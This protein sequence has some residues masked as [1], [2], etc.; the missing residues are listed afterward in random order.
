MRLEDELVATQPQDD[1]RVA[2]VD[3]RV[4]GLAEMR[5]VQGHGASIGVS[6]DAL[7][8]T[9]LARPASGA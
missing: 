8:Q 5:D 6:A 4:A 7:A 9:V 1:A 3:V 2:A